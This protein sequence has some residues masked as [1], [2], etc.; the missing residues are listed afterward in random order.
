MLLVETLK[1]PILMVQQTIE[2]VNTD[3]ATFGYFST[4]PLTN[5][6]LTTT[7]SSRYLSLKNLSIA[8]NPASQTTR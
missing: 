6:V 7:S 3:T 1:Q 2:P 4:I 8:T 5:V